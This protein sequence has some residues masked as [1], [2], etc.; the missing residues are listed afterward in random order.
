MKMGNMRKAYGTALLELGRE[1]PKVVA[2]EADLGKSTMSNMFEA[3]FP[4]RYFQMGI[5]E[6][7]MMSV[8]A[9]LSLTG[10]VAFA[11][12]FAVFASGRPYDQIRSSVAIPRL[13]VKI[14]G[15]SAGL[16]DFGDG[17]THQSIDDITIMRVL[18]NMHVF[19]PADAAE[20]EKIVKAMADIPGP[21]Y[22]RVN[23]NDVPEVTNPDEPFV[24]GKV[25][26]LRDGGD[27]V[28]F[29]TGYMVHQA[30]QAAEALGKDGISARVVNVATIKPFDVKGVQE[31]ARGMKAAVSVEEASVFGGLGSAVCE[32]L[33]AG[34]AGSQ[35]PVGVIGIQDTFGTCAQSYEELL[36]HYSL[37][38]E[39]IVAKVK[40]L[41]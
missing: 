3:E 2:L 30:L 7:N 16:S 12:T 5:A 27:V 17:K 18:P 15:S 26:T 13:N 19:S 10:H 32:A 35:V 31:A 37:M 24:M 29:A 20:T 28:I 25:K 33:C 14:C 36:R 41:L 22:I 6:A 8:A 34:P 38:P 11:S 9:G 21:C 4:A 40:G 39:D 23:R 1:N